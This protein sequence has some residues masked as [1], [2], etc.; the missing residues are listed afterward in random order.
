M[1]C[2]RTG[3]SANSDRVPGIYIV[4]KSQIFSHE[5][6]P[7]SLKPIIDDESRFQLDFTV[8]DT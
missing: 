5:A 1:Q 8:A 4:G 3:P 2:P 7:F 6:L